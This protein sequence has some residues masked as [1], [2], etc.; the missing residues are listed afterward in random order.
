[1]KAFPRSRYWCFALVAGGGLAWD[2]LSK[3]WVFRELGY[4][5]HSSEWQ[6]AFP[7]LWGRF[8][9]RL[10]TRFNEGALFGIGQ[11]YGWLFAV[12]SV[13]AVSGILYWL[14]RRGEARSAWLT[15]T[16][17]LVS[18]GA[19]GNLYDRLHL[20]GCT[21][22]GGRPR[23]GVRDFIDCT[24]PGLKFEPP[25]SL[26]LIPEYEWPTF[27]FADSFLVAGACMLA[28][29][30]FFGDASCQKPAARGPIPCGGP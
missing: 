29:N 15:V 27:N 13:L 9:L 28:L 2:L 18:A 14:F 10:T 20:H 1:M 6:L 16:L 23:Y 3:S 26:R 22:P 24:I 19:L 11:G 4:E 25:F 5:F 17:A 12:I 7:L 30:A 21:D 8:Q